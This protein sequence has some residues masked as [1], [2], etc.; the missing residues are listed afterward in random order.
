MKLRNLLILGAS[1]ASCLTASAE[2]VEYTI[3]P[4]HSGINFK[5]RNFVSKVPGVFT[6]FQGK[7][8]YD[9]ENPANSKVTATINADSVDTRNERRDGHLANEDFFNVG[10]FPTIEFASTT[11]TKTGEGT[12]KV[13]GTLT[14]LGVDKPV[15]LEVNFLGE[16]QARRNTVSGWEVT[17]VLDRSDWGMTFGSPATSLEVEVEINIQAR[18]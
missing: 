11:W 3:D 2:V 8:H 5:V 1:V 14:M 9:K 13:A 7:I 17:T 10:K 16:M 4:V 6:E 12:Y 18:R 15:E